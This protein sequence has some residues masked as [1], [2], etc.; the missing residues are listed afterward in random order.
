MNY[1]QKTAALAVIQA[2]VDHFR[3]CWPVKSEVAKKFGWKWG[4]NER[5]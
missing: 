2:L 1:L 5:T 4:E 3:A